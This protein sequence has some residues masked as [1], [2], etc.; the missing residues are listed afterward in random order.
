MPLHPFYGVPSGTWVIVSGRENTG[1]IS[2]VLLTVSRELQMNESEHIFRPQPRLYAT[3]QHALL[4]HKTTR[5]TITDHDHTYTYIHT[6]SRVSP[7][8]APYSSPSL[9]RTSGPH[10]AAF[11][12]VHPSFWAVCARPSH[13]HLD[14]VVVCALHT[15]SC[16]LSPSRHARRYAL[17][18]NLCAPVLRCARLLR[19]E[20]RL[21]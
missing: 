18:C 2:R 12:I 15:R 13:L 5:P 4:I 9:S 19:L 20:L 17:R 11:V 14:I 3:N 8:P 16:A 1:S 7:A 10:G 6:R 21:Y